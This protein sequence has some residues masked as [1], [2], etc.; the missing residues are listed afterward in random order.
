[1]VIVMSYKQI[2]I[3][4][5]LK[6]LK[7]MG[8]DYAYD[9]DKEMIVVTR[10]IMG[11]KVKIFVTFS[12]AWVHTTY[13]GPSIANLDKDKKM[14]VMRKLLQ[15]NGQTREI[16]FGLDSGE[17]IIIS[18]ESNIIGLTFDNY[19]MEFGA[20]P[21][22]IKML[23]KEVMPIVTGKKPKEEGKEKEEKSK[24]KEVNVLKK[25]LLDIVAKDSEKSD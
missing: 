9:P 12:D 16:K 3:N 14:E 22:A 20:I 10:K 8:E 24:E 7:L 1:M 23:F 19:Y 13:V 2:M 21:Y 11:E 4:S 25:V 5:V 17:N 15:I 18:V 6:Y